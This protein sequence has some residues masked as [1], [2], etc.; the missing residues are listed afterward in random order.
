VSNRDRKTAKNDLTPNIDCGNPIQAFDP[1]PIRNSGCITQALNAKSFT[2]DLTKK[3]RTI[4]L[5]K[6]AG[7]SCEG[8]A[9]GQ[10]HSWDKAGK[11]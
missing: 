8:D 4:C 1:W 10:E 7:E 3:H 5:K 2:M 11:S 6:Y 9:V